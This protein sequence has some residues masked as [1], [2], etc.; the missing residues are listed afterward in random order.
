MRMHG[1]YSGVTIKKHSLNIVYVEGQASKSVA[2]DSSFPECR[3]PAV[4][5]VCMYVY[6]YVG[7]YAYV[8]VYAYMGPPSP[9]PPLY[10]PSQSVGFHS[11]G[12]ISIG[13][14]RID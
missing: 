1:L 4:Q 7:V 11:V 12:L 14:C 10:F 8:C 2:R 6:M 13:I 9:H 5:N 3:L